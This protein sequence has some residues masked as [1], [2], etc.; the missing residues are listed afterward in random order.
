MSTLQELIRK[1]LAEKKNEAGNGTGEGTSVLVPSAGVSSNSVPSV[2]EHE[3]VSANDTEL[4]HVAD[5]TLSESEN[6][7]VERTYVDISP[8]NQ[9]IKMMLAEL[10]QALDAQLPDFPNILANIHKKIKAD[11]ACVT[12]LSEDE[13][14]QIVRGLM[15]HTQ[16]EI[17]APKQVKE[18][19][20]LA[21][22]TK[23]LA[24]D[25]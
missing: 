19:K 20:K 5:E 25:L 16:V 6:A 13:I 12:V 23:I 22:N 4:E 17:I 21:K 15:K 9:Q 2:C 8:E 1:R 14:H 10:R 7:S 11:P 18:A 3:S 24:S